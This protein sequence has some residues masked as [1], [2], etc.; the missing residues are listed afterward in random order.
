MKVVIFIS[1][2]ICIF[3]KFSITFQK[4][5]EDNNKIHFFSVNKINDKYFVT[6]SHDL[7]AIA[8][9][10]YQKSYN[11][12]GWGK[13]YILTNN[14]FDDKTQAYAAGYLEGYITRE[15][16]YDHY[17][18][19]R[20]NEYGKKGFPHNIKKF[21]KEN[22]EYMENLVEL[23]PSDIH[24]QTIIKYFLQYK[25]MVQ[26]Y[27]DNSNFDEQISL[28]DFNM[29]TSDGDLE[30]ISFY[31]KK[32]SNFFNNMK[33]DELVAYK[34][35]HSHCTALIRIN[36]DFSDI[37]IGHN[38]WVDYYM[39][40]RLIK[41]YEFNFN[42]DSKFSKKVSFTSYPGKIGSTD[43][44]YTTS[45]KLVI[46]ETTNSV[47]NEKILEKITPKAYLN[48][49]R[50]MTA[51]RLSSNSKEWV[52]NFVKHNSGT[53]NNQYMILDL[54]QIDFDKKT[55]NENTLIINEQMPG[56]TVTADLTEVL[57]NKKFWPSFNIPY[58]PEVRKKFGYD[59]LINKF[60]ILGN[61]EDEFMINT[62]L[63]YEDNDRHNIL[64]RDAVKVNTLNE[65]KEI[66]R[67]NNY[68]HD[69][70]SMNRPGFSLASRFDLDHGVQKMC[71]G[72]IDAKVLSAKEIL[73]EDNS[74]FHAI[75]G[76]TTSEKSQIGEFIWS[77]S[78][79]CKEDY[80][81][82]INDKFSYP[83]IEY[84]IPRF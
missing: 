5:I 39:G 38:T 47:L 64:R 17:R 61:E 23:N 4:N 12:D 81:F 34:H 42:D 16:I 2:L 53:Y 21:F 28:I 1:L 7:N 37:F 15:K 59:E 44:Y 43:D 41:T 62:T 58:F 55:L 18:N 63:N 31:E 45:N 24:S 19:I 11:N 74:K 9:C 68:K 52:D 40:N 57:K 48:W 77:K 72:A 30:E 32:S 49:I 70:E 25:G 46:Q 33:A 78:K 80:H 20:L 29:I 71:M 35:K 22:L 66:M 69:K 82:G 50:T 75:S 79:T 56:K 73:S 67:Y 27:N 83:W 51:N 10:K 65:F 6:E 60:K 84:E 36:D 8:T 3:S 13:L 76:P 54:K 26:G 14:S